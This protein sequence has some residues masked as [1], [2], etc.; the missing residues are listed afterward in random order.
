MEH[1][2]ENDDNAKATVWRTAI[3]DV[4]HRRHCFP[5]YK[6]GAKSVKPTTFRVVGMPG[7]SGRFAQHAN[8]HAPKPEV[9]L[10]G[11]D[12]FTKRYHTPAAKEYAP[13]LCEAMIHA[14]FG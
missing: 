2:T 8:H 14:S 5:Q 6:Y 3:Q 13:E 1:P 10:R 11:Y 9:Q 7:L 12:V 4:H